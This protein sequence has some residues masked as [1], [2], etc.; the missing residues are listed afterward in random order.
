MSSIYRTPEG[1]RAIRD[2]YE[3]FLKRWPVPS[4][5]LRV[6]TRQGET[7]V[8]SC[9]NEHAPP[10]V[11]FHGSAFNSASWMGDIAAWAPHFHVHAVDMIGEPGLSAPSRPPLG[12]DAYALWLDDVFEALSVR[13][14]SLV[15]VSLGGWLALDYATRRPERVE[16]LV[17]LNPGGIGAQKFG[18]IAKA[19]ALRMCGEWGARKARETI[20]GRIPAAAPPS[21]RAFM[22]FVALI[23]QNFRPRLAKLPIFSDEALRRLTMPVLAILGG[24]DALL[25]AAT[26]KRRLEQ[27]APH[28]D[29]RLLPEA[30]HLLPKQTLAVVE[31]L[32]HPKA[33]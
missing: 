21:V 25:D 29:V 14:A 26:T 19:L 17:L 3:Q 33:A 8:I 7:F 31:F 23:H 12:S 11:L 30:G 32:H 27:A 16:N 20:L 24:K 6:P 18:A 9:G 2:R 5:Q 13:R 1:A 4:R 22:E 15:G 10:L 28:A